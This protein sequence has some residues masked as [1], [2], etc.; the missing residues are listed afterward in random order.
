[1][2]VAR[3][4]LTQVADTGALERVIDEVLGTNPK[5]LEDW[6]KGKTAAAQALFGLVMK[7]TSG[8]AN[9]AIVKRLLE[10]KLQKI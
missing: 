7:A 1:M 2:I 4:G 5:P 6:R 10:A 9:P 8:K 3:E